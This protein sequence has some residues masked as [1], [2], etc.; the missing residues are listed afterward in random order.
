VFGLDNVEELA[1]GVAV[2]YPVVLRVRPGV[3][4]IYAKIVGWVA[5]DLGHHC[6]GIVGVVDH[7]IVT[8]YGRD[9]GEEVFFELEADEFFGADVAHGLGPSG[10]CVI[11]G[12]IDGLSDEIDPSAVSNG[13]SECCSQRTRGD[14][15]AVV[16]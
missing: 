1:V 9:E 6:V 12:I 7:V 5:V 16:V 2:P 14:A 15:D 13:E 8:F 3:D 10:I 11:P 4:P